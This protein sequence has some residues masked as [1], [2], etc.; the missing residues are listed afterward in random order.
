MSDR[1]P[2]GGSFDKH[3]YRPHQ[4]QM[5]RV[6]T[7]AAQHGQALPGGRSPQGLMPPAGRRNHLQNTLFQPLFIQVEKAVT[8][9]NGQQ[10]TFQCIAVVSQGGFLDPM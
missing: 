1:T 7:N 5:G 8:A 6:F 4:V 3:L 2:S 9:K 10:V